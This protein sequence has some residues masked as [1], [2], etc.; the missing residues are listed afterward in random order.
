MKRDQNAKNTSEQPNKPKTLTD[1]L[2][3]GSEDLERRAEE[4]VGGVAA[5][6][7]GGA[8]ARD[9][10]AGGGDWL[11]KRVVLAGD[12]DEREIGIHGSFAFCVCVCW[13]WKFKRLS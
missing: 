13:K 3:V 11:E 8:E 4:E 6:G 5:S 1:L 9:G 12:L 7:S 2:G 10:V